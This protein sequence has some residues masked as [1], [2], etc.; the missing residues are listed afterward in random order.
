MRRLLIPLR[1]WL[2]K[3]PHLRRRLTLI[4]Y[5]FPALDM[6]LRGLLHSAE[7]PNRMRQIDASH[8]SEDG[9]HVMSR[10]RARMPDR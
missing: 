10:L 9:R 6:R 5:R 7:R 1:Q 2:A 3:R 4:I 8:L